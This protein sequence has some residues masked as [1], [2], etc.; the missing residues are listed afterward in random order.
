MWFGT[1]TPKRHK[2]RLNLGKL[3]RSTFVKITA[4]E[5]SLA[6]LDVFNLLKLIT[7]QLFILTIWLLLTCEYVNLR[8]VSF[9]TPKPENVRLEASQK[10]ILIWEINDPALKI[11]TNKQHNST[12]SANQ[13]NL[14]VLKFPAWIAF[15]KPSNI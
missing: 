12:T 8:V 3:E 6:S 13:T 7:S 11:L 4:P 14:P 9:G 5:P 15:I 2:K 10:T 1:K